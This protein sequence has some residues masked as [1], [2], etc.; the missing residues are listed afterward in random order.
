VTN[1]FF[2]TTGVTPA[3][4]GRY[5]ATID[6]TWKLRPLPQGGIVSALAL[7]A[8]TE[9]LDDPGQTIRSLHTAFVGQVAHGPLSIDVELLRRGRSMS[10][11]RAEASNPGS[12]RGHL[13][14]GIF[15]STR[16]GFSFT[17]LRP[18]VGVPTPDDCRSFRD[19]L[20][21]GALQF[22]PMPFWTER[23]EGRTA[24]GHA[25]WEEYV[26]DRAER[27]MWYRFDH[28]PFLA[29]GT[30]DPLALVVLAD[31]MPGAVGE[32][33]GPEDRMWFAPSVD[34]TVH[35]LDV[36]RSPWLLAHNRARHAGDGYASADMALWDCG[37]DG[38]GTPRLVAYAT[39]LFLFSFPT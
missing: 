13:T 1:P 35:L 11:L 39:Q 19:P 25:P 38:A 32:K 29:N 7:R 2:T 22:E 5:G 12:P 9:H 37:E 3:G 26:P 34:L 14:T 21:D 23:V 33:I 16:S 18:P 4:P 15:G 24:L 28:P 30:I 36:C 8:M 27:A 6:E 20:P 17:D 31:T 10:H